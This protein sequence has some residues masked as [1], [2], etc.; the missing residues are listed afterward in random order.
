ME[1]NN[2]NPADKI[3]LEHL[4]PYR[5]YMDTKQLERFGDYLMHKQPSHPFDWSELEELGRIKSMNGVKIKAS[6]Y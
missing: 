5:Q 1:C 2:H 4:L 3:T 6:N